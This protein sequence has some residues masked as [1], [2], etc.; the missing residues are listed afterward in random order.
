VRQELR[1]IATGHGAVIRRGIHHYA[2]FRDDSGVR[3]FSA[4]CPHLGCVVH[5]NAAE[6]SFDCPCHGSRFDT[7]GRVMN[8][9]AGSP[10]LPVQLEESK[11]EEQPWR[12]G[13]RRE[14][15]RHGVDRRAAEDRSADRLPGEPRR[16]GV[17]REGGE[18]DHRRDER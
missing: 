16:E 3:V 1:D 4:T 12:Q 2:A 10:L 7:Q 17:H 9:P 14:G 11:E 8:G 5:W 6:K 13:S 15:V 18:S